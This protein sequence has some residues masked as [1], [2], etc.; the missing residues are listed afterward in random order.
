[1]A[2]ESSPASRPAPAPL[3]PAAS[4]VLLREHAGRVETLLTRRHAAM[5]F[6]GLWV[7]AGGKVED[8]DR[9]AAAQVAVEPPAM[10]RHHAP[11]VWLDPGDVLP[12]FTAAARELVE[13]TGLRLA[14]GADTLVHFAHWVTPPGLPRRFDTHFFL[15]VAAAGSTD[16]VACGEVDEFCWIEPHVAVE[17]S[18]SEEL[19][20]APVTAFTLLE[21]A[22]ALD[23]HGSLAAM[24]A[25][26]RG[27]DVLPIMP[28]LD[29]D[30]SPPGALL[31]WHPR[32][33]ALPG[34]GTC[35]A[36]PIPDYYRGLPD[37]WVVPASL[38]PRK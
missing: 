12:F 38:L 24:L 26:E 28:K 5:S 21:V 18:R 14:G 34:E 2:D 32:Y 36:M 7:F 17:A 27:R 22:A 20:A 30:L 11:D 33:H 1:M 13:E 35:A 4:V 15:G 29:R 8:S 10:R 25:G 31:P 16:G 6:G 9:V 19:P 3:V 37:R 23:R